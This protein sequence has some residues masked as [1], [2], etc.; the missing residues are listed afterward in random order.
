MLTKMIFI[1]AVT[2]I[3][4]HNNT[5]E[6][7]KPYL[8]KTNNNTVECKLCEGIV[9]VIDNDIKYGN[10]T[11]C[12]IKNAIE[13]ICNKTTDPI[14]NKECHVVLESLNKIVN[15][16]TKNVP[17]VSICKNLGYC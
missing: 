9:T 17:T 14:G 11:F 1:L 16:I 15:W 6:T 10:K 5:C 13:Y 12:K 4:T 2:Q 7:Q 3:N 8:T